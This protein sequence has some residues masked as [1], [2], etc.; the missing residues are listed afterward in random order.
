M[1][2]AEKIQNFAV[3]MPSI[4]LLQDLSI[5]EAICDV[6]QAMLDLSPWQTLEQPRFKEGYDHVSLASHVNS[7]IDCALAVSKIV[8]QY[9]GITF[10]EQRIIAFGLLHDVDKVVEYTFD[11]NHELVISDLG[12]KIQ[13]GVLS[14][15]LAHEHGFDMDMLHMILTHTTDS[16]LRPQIKEAILFGHVDLCDWELTCKF[17]K[18]F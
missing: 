9:H 2:Q 5:A 7:T 1:T 17:A 15:I 8:A 14:A 18:D 6:W 13:H 11:E 3:Y 10:D 4:Q 12:R 16:K